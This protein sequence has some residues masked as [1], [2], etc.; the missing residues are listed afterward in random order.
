MPASQPKPATAKRT[1]ARTGPNAAHQLLTAIRDAVDAGVEAAKVSAVI[2]MALG[3]EGA[4]QAP[5]W[6]MCAG[7]LTNYTAAAKA[8]YVG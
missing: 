4:A 6:R 7:A 5:G 1:N 8:R 2:E 3:A